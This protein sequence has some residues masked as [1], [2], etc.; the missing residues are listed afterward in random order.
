MKIGIYGGSFN[1]TH[2]GHIAVAEYAIKE[3]KLDKLYFVPAFKSPFKS[4]VKYVDAQHRVNMIELVKPEKS[5][6]SLFEVNR[7]GVSYTIDTVRHFKQ[8]F[9]DDELFLLIGSDNVYKLNKW[10]EINEI[11]SK[12]K[13][14]VFRRSGEFSKLNIKRYNAILFDNPI[15]DYAS[16]WFRKGYMDNVESVVM[17]YI[18]KNYLYIPE[19]MS[20]MLDAKRHKHSISVGSFAAKYAKL[21]KTD[22]KK[23]WAVGCLHDITKSWPKEVHREY[24]RNKGY[25]DTQIKDYELH[26]ITGMLWVRDEYQLDDKEALDAILKHTSLAKEMSQLD[27]VIFA[28]DKLCEGRT[29]EGIQKDRE[30]ILKDFDAGFSKVVSE[31]KKI[32]IEMERPLSEEQLEIYKGWM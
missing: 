10:K 7:K 14:A 6:V 4:K 27:R 31:V 8:K 32:L 20:N 28:A 25:D 23:A 2:K 11:V 22:S 16:S 30:L 24:L 3:L 21:A 5:E 12:T 15:Y 29:H 13:I 9:P 1:P 19:I 18:S 26:S 17:K